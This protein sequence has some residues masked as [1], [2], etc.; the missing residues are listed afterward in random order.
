[1]RKVWVDLDALI[2]LKSLMC[3]RIDGRS[4][5]RTNQNTFPVW[6]VD[7]YRNCSV[8]SEWA[9]AFVLFFS[10]LLLTTKLFC[11]N[12][13]AT[14]PCR[15]KTRYPVFFFG[16][17]LSNLRNVYVFFLSSCSMATWTYANHANNAFQMEWYWLKLSLSLTL[18][19]CVCLAF[20]N[21]IK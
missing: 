7:L 5:D 10:W 13:D 17:L 20:L 14:I 15:K 1:M 2:K 18:T 11:A 6:M 19:L 21:K 9:R 8:F 3:Q 16:M 12:D 4:M